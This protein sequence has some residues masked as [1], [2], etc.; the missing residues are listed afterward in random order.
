[1]KC[2]GG[3]TLLELLVVLAVM[4]LIAAALPGVAL[5]GIAGVRLSGKVA[6][7][8]YRLQ[9]ARELAVDTGQA[10]TLKL[11]AVAT[12]TGIFAQGPGSSKEIRFFPD[13][14]SSGGR[15]VVSFGGRHRILVVDPLKARL[16]ME[17]GG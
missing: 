8:A 13:G 14:S 1:M 9:R 4:G 2:E 12:S 16:R 11:D 3:Y 15:W 7:V 10:V 17:N 6:E 5:P